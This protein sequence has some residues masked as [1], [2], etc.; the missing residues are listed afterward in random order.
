[1]PGGIGHTRGDRARCGWRRA[2]AQTLDRGAQ[3]RLAAGRY[4]GTCT[5]GTLGPKDVDRS[6]RRARTGGAV[7]VGV[8]PAELADRG[9]EVG[10]A[11]VAVA[12]LVRERQDAR[13]QRVPGQLGQ[14]L[15]V[16]QR[17][18]VGAPSQALEPAPRGRVLLRA[19]PARPRRRRGWRRPGAR[20]ARR[21]RPFARGRAGARVAVLPLSAGAGVLA[22]Q[23]RC[24]NLSTS[25]ACDPTGMQA[26]L[27]SLPQRAPMLRTQGPCQTL[28]ATI[29]PAL[30]TQLSSTCWQTG[31]SSRRRS[32]TRQGTYQLV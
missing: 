12:V 25:A 26:H 21:W 23:A 4:R 29:D 17:H 5:T 24:W 11:Q 1:M 19:S 14:R 7:V 22:A 20:G 2:Q 10:Q 15:E 9:G 32:A 13:R 3:S 28:L 30:A 27:V 8:Q 31:F 16:R 18:A 6:G